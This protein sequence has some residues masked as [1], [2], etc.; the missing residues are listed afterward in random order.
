MDSFGGQHYLTQ[1]YIT[2]SNMKRLFTFIL[3]PHSLPSFITFPIGTPSA[4]MVYFLI[5]PC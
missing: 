4:L 5:R 3:K 1:A 2:N